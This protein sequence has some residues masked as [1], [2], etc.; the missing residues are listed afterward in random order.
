MQSDIVLNLNNAFHKEVEQQQQWTNKDSV[1]ST[2]QG[3][4][5]QVQDGADVQIPRLPTQVT[6]A[7]F[8]ADS[9]EILSR[10]QSKKGWLLCMSLIYQLFLLVQFLRYDNF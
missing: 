8:A 9:E 7:T 1:S 2:S 5:R 4:T 3:V 10:N 6:S